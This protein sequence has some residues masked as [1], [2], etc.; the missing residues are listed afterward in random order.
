MR[1]FPCEQYLDCTGTFINLDENFALLPGIYY[2]NT[3]FIFI[4]F[5]VP[6]VDKMYKT[7][8]KLLDYLEL[9][10]VQIQVPTPVLI[11]KFI[12]LLNLPGTEVQ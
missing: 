10:D 9:R 1:I 3:L 7:T 4:L 5:K 8:Q 11:S 12:V 6:R 2:L